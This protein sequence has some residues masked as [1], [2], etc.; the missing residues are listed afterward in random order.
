MDE[1]GRLYRPRDR[2]GATHLA[3]GWKGRIRYTVSLDGAAQRACWNAFRPGR[4]GFP[5]RA[6]ARLPGLLGAGRC[7]E[8]AALQSIREAVGCESE[9]SC[10]RAGAAGPWHK[11]TILLLDRNTAE[12]RCFVKTGNGAAVNAL[13]DNEARW[14]HKLREEANLARQV[15]E[16]LAHL[17][18]EDFCF[19]AQRPLEGSQ[20]FKLAAPQLDFLRKLQRCTLKAMRYPE[21]RLSMTLDA[22]LSHLRGHLT[23]DWFT[24]LERAIGQTARSFSN[25]SIVLVA[26]HNDF[27]PWNIRVRDRLA[28]V[29]DWEYAAEEQLPLFDPLHFVLL[30]MA[31]GGRPI[32][33]MIEAARK[34]AELCRTELAAENCF[35]PQAQLVAYLLNVCTLYLSSVQ[36][37]CKPDPVVEKYTRLIDVLCPA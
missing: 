19:V 8:G 12:S 4:L 28:C 13:L 2:S 26:G 22:R 37:Q 14:L 16:L 20:E 25:A 18:S 3:L 29:F 35:A 31:L 11:D 27:T 10:C 23:E 7:T 6:M 17:S 21:S 36:D 30:P 32:A 15:P 24:R 1:A 9:L 5:L 33:A 34:T